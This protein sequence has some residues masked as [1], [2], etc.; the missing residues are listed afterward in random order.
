MTWES[1]L[2]RNYYIQKRLDLITGPNWFDSGLGLIAPDGPST[3]RIFADTNAPVRFYRVQAVRPLALDPKI[4]P[5]LADGL[6]QN[7]PRGTGE[8]MFAT[9]ENS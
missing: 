8:V 7:S 1:V 5:R 4:Y 6:R 9:W 2:T 3:T